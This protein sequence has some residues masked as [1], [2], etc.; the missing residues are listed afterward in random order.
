MFGI[1]LGASKRKSK[2]MKAACSI[3]LLLFAPLTGP[4]ADTASLNLVKTIALPGVKGRFDH[5]SI[6]AKHH[7]LF[8]AALGNGSVEI[9][10]VEAG[11][12]LKSLGGVQK[13]TG[14]LYLPEQNYLAVADG[15]GS[16]LKVFDAT[17]FNLQ[18]TVRSLDD[19]DNVRYDAASKLIYVGYGEGAVSIIDSATLKQTGALKLS[20][21]PESFQLEKNGSRMFVNVPDSKKVVVVDRQK[22]T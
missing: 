5:F 14:L 3:F 1:G 10:D 9:I 18:A 12:H 19:A 21:H 17:S 6:D 20:A 2:Y 11:R 16:A 7:R 22:R 4:S 8:V 13:P 15:G